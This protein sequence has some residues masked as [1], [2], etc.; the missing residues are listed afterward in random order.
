MSLRVRTYALLE[1]AIEDGAERGWLR[2]HKDVDSPDVEAIHEAIRECVLFE[3]ME[4]FE[5]D[6][7]AMPVKADA[8]K[9]RN[10]GK[11]HSV[12]LID[13]AGYVCL[14]CGDVESLKARELRKYR[15]VPGV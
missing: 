1:R 2:A 7:D 14:A 9:C 15:E 5:C 13:H 11:H 10:C 6:D 8:F 12:P 4:Y 3:V